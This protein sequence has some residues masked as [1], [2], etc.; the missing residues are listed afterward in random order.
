MT[1]DQ[2]L[3]DLRR[4]FG[5]GRGVLY[6][7]D[8]AV[9][10]GKSRKATANL[11]SRNSLPFE[12]KK[13]GG[14]RCANIYDVADWLAATDSDPE[15]DTPEES[16]ANAEGQAK[17]PG[18]PFRKTS[19]PAQGRS[20]VAEKLFQLRLENARQI[21][22]FSTNLFDEIARL[23]IVEV[24]E[25]MAFA[26][27]LPASQ[28]VLSR[29]TI[30]PSEGAESVTEKKWLIE[31]REEAVRRTKELW[32]DPY[33]MSASRLI[34]RQGRKVLFRGHGIGKRSVLIDLVGC[35][36]SEDQDQ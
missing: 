15:L 36:H 17:S 30:V 27:A 31:S 12:V 14:L 32:S 20:T 22:Q 8:I 23:F 28:F 35:A 25:L 18:K 1:P 33:E 11:I 16:A 19:A 24:T 26:A 10:L 2:A 29:S 21:A 5:L 3:N 4:E 7:K 9:L 34:L 6:A 13:V